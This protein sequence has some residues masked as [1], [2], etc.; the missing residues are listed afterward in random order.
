M[1]LGNFSTSFSSNDAR[2]TTKGGVPWIC[3]LN[4]PKIGFKPTEA[5]NPL[6]ACPWKPIV[7][8]HLPSSALFL[9]TRN[10]ELCWDP[11]L[12]CNSRRGI[13][14]Y[15]SWVGRLNRLGANKELLDLPSLLPSETPAFALSVTSS[16]PWHAQESKRG[17][18]KQV[19]TNTSFCK[20][21]KKIQKGWNIEKMFKTSINILVFLVFQYQD[22][23]L[24]QKKL[25]GHI[26]KKTSQQG[27]ASHSGHGSTGGLLS[28]KNKSQS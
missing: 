2:Q 22:R 7:T 25:P 13:D 10:K 23:H 19:A 12:N 26:L 1:K 6:E 4:I 11:P 9:L 28:K 16:L 15:Q 5:S 27:A 20:H 18:L 17:N 3:H 14:N 21:P 24:K 8:E